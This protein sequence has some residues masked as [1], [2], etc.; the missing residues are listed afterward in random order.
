M[1]LL[2]SLY[3]SF[4]SLPSPMDILQQS[5]D[6]GR[7]RQAQDQA[8]YILTRESECLSAESNLFSLQLDLEDARARY[9]ELKIH[10]RIAKERVARLEGEE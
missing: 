7:R 1:K 9:E 2:S 10:V 5:L 4:F 3:Q 6:S 8:D